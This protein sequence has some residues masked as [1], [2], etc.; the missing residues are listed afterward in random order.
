[1]G[2]KTG[3][4]VKKIYKMKRD[5]KWEIRRK[6]GCDGKVKHKTLLAAEYYLNSMPPNKYLTIYKCEFC[7]CYH[8]GKDQK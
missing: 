2:V 7:N 3:N 1:M 5:E 6:H 4:F 8:I